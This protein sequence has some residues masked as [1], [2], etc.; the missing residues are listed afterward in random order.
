MKIA[1]LDFIYDKHESLEGI[2]TEMRKCA[3]ERT[4]IDYIC[5]EKVNSLDYM[6]YE[7][8]VLPEL[9]KTVGEIERKGYD[10]VIIGCCLDPC[11]NTLREVYKDI[12]IAGPFEAAAAIAKSLGRKFSIIATRPKAQEQYL[13][14]IHRT[15]CGNALASIR[16]LNLKVLEL[17]EDEKRLHDKMSSEIQL[18]MENDFA[19]VILLACTMETGQYRD[20]QKKFGIPVIDPTIAALKYAEMMVSARDMCG[21]SVSGKGTYETPPMDELNKFLSKEL[22]ILW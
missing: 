15:G 22:K 9:I 7:T 14:T 16:Y 6:A 18:A 17:Q 13:E 21:W 8:I 19:D 1:Y 20:L 5:M 4:C 2:V 10:A 3:N 12:I 11:I